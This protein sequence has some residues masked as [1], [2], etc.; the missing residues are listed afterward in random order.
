MTDVAEKY[1]HLIETEFS[2]KGITLQD[3]RVPFYSSVTRNV[4]QTAKQLGPNYWKSNLVSPVLF[5][6]ALRKAM[7]D[8]SNRLFLEVGPHSTLAGPIRQLVGQMG[9]KCQYIPTMI[10]DE[11]CQKSLLSAFGQLYQ[12]G[13]PIDLA[14]LI[15]RS[16]VLSDLPAYPW[17]HG[18]GFWYESRI[19]KDWRL[20]KFGHHPLL[21]IRVPESTDLNPIWRNVLNTEDELWLHDHKIQQNTVFP[22]AGYC[23]MAG[24]AV[25][26]ITGDGTGYSLKHIVAHTALVLSDFKPVE[27]ITT[28]SQHRITDTANSHLWD[29]VIASHSGT[30]WV[31]HCEGQVCISNQDAKSERQGESLLR[32][33]QPSLWYETMARTGIVYGPAFQGLTQIAS[34]TTQNIANGTLVCLERPG[35][36]L[37]PST[38]DAGLQLLLVAMA[39]G[40]GRNFS[41]LK[42]PTMIEQLDIWSGAPTLQATAWSSP[43]SDAGIECV[44]D[45]RLVMRLTGIRLTPLET[46]GAHL[47]VDKNAAARLEW[48]P[49]FDF[50]DHS[51]LFQPRTS[52]TQE[53]VL[54]EEMTLLCILDCEESLEHLTPKQEHFAKYRAW[55]SREA[56]RARLG[57][58][59]VVE[60]VNRF[61]NLTHASRAAMIE[62]RYQQ[63]SRMSNKDAVAEGIYR[64]WANAGP[65]FTGE[66]DTLDILTQD[67]VLTKIYNVVSFGHSGFIQ[68]LSHTKPGLRIM[69]VGAGTGGTTQTFLHDLVTQD[70]HPKYSKYTFTDISAG[71]FPKARQRFSYAPN[72]DFRVFDISQ[73]PL[74]QG[75]EPQSYDLILAPNVVHATVRLRDTLQ[76]LQCLL[77]PGGRLVLTELSAVIRTPNYIFG[78]FS[79]WWLGEDDGR[80]DEPYVSVERWDS[81]LKAAGFT[82]VETAVYD[83]EEPYQYCAAIVSQPLITIDNSRDVKRV[84]VLFNQPNSGVGE[85]VSTKLQDSGYDICQRSLDD[86]LPEGV[87]I[88]SVLDLETPFFQDINE[89]R[90]TSFQ[91][92]LRSMQ[93]QKLLWLTRP[94]QISCAD[95][96]RALSIGMARTI[97]SEL[98]IPY[99][100]L[101]VDSSDKNFGDL[102]CK[103]FAHIE[104]SEDTESLLPDREYAVDQ[105]KIKIGRYTPYA[106]QRQ[107]CGPEAMNSNDF[108]I[109]IR[110]LNIRKLGL[111]E[112][113]RWTQT[114]G[115]KAIA[116]DHVEIK[117]RSIGLN[118]RDVVF[119]MGIIRS[120]SETIPLGLEMAGVISR[121]GPNGGNF[122]IGDR[123]MA[124]SANGCIAT[125]AAIPSSLAIK[126]PEALSFEAAATMPICFATAIRSLIDVGQLGQGQSVLIHS[127]AGGVGHAAIQICKLLGAE[128][129]V[130][131]GNEEK[132]Q[133]LTDSMGIA[134][135]HIFDSRS[136]GFV[137]GLMA[138][139]GGRGADLVLNSLSGDLLHASWKC[140]AKF[141]KMIE[142]GKRDLMEHGQLDMQTFLANRSYCCV[143]IAQMAQE[144]PMVI[145]RYVCWNPSTL[146]V[147]L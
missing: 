82:G 69:E 122:K 45:G 85:L 104:A 124:I 17:D 142:L 102:V 119:A 37:H 6:P 74:K 1:L 98:N 21:G 35:F 77:T 89:A 73:D 59:P 23:T 13:I 117:T 14:A 108:G 96:S 121:V 66:G 144:R 40:I 76:N 19:S 130:T 93:G 146:S 51:K 78:N 113:L 131:A 33:V 116:E 143:D 83:A 137:S 100:T 11:D 36:L 24:E 46:E 92:M 56:D 15:P 87:D 141:G 135:S 90:F 109:K 29:F 43:G 81:E 7:H 22:F 127:S 4:I 34:S 97:R 99:F 18:P 47:K 26:Q 79:G 105:G 25:L 106:L 60:D 136:E 67:N 53:T 125:R 28:L 3:P 49:H 39:K 5:A 58:Y 16:K 88:V 2:I 133:Y 8:D 91:T 75:F 123:V 42:I 147:D 68:V 103:T 62:D 140:V 30:S 139:T 134:R 115:P 61:L 50:I 145:N 63:L 64:I 114:E 110:T 132:V 54:Q 20:R 32:K 10:R 65:I 71:F 111:L 27:M 9:L 128:I 31:K 95:P 52:N 126:I 101:E 44:S 55:L 41:D 38:I 129:F 94:S 118:F 12:T 86:S 72:M 84:V 120:E 112:S 138:Q 80:P 70:G 48:R 107:L 57:T